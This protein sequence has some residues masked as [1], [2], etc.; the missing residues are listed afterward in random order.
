MYDIFLFNI[1]KFL[2]TDNETL[3]ND[4]VPCVKRVAFETF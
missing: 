3:A 4:I 1:D 2:Q